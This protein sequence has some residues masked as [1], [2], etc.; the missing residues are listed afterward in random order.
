MTIE[1]IEYNGRRISYDGSGK[2]HMMGGEGPIMAKYFDIK[3]NEVFFDVGAADSQWTLY[4]LASGAYVYAIEPSIPCANRPHRSLHGSGANRRAHLQMADRP[5]IQYLRGFSPADRGPFVH[6][7]EAT[8]NFIRC[9]QC[10]RQQTIKPG[11]TEEVVQSLGWKRTVDVWTCPFCAG[12][13][14]KLREIFDRQDK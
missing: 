9:S 2:E 10:S 5:R 13:T 12:N 4:A 7:C 8:M 3:P 11:V 14:E 1:T 6:H